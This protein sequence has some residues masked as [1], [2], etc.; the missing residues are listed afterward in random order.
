MP[1]PWLAFPHIERYS[2]GW[3]WGYGEDYIG[4]F[5]DWWRTLSHAEQAEYQT[6]FP[7]PVTWKGWWEHE[8]TTEVFAHGDFCIDLWQQS[9]VPKYT[10]T[11]LRQEITD[12]KQYD[13]C[14]FWGHQPAKDGSITKS[15]FSQWWLQDFW[16]VAHNYCCMEQ[17]M[18][19]Q[20]AELFGDTEIRQQILLMHRIH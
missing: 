8:D 15:C 18:M 7:E 2:I 19:E 17:F 20:K 3:R 6:L 4:W 16:S 13:L 12:G 9:G 10:T 11:R 5:F 14:L 1:P